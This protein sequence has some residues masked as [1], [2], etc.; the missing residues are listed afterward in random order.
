MIAQNYWAL[1]ITNVYLKLQ[2]PGLEMFL[3]YSTCLLNISL[4]EAYV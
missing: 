3:L 1:N 4:K 2:S